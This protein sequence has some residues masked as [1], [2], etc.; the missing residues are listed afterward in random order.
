MHF[1]K[2]SKEIPAVGINAE[3]IF[4]ASWWPLILLFLQKKPCVL[5]PQSSFSI[6]KYTFR[7]YP[8]FNCCSV[9]VLP[10]WWK[11]GILTCTLNDTLLTHYKLY[12]LL[13]KHYI[14]CVQQ[15]WTMHHGSCWR[16]CGKR[17]SLD[18]QG[19]H[20][21]RKPKWFL[22]TMRHVLDTKGRHLPGGIW[23]ISKRYYV[24]ELHD[25]HTRGRMQ[26]WQLKMVKVGNKALELGRRKEQSQSEG[27]INS[28]SVW[29]V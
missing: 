5:M 23:K 1:D 12:N 17:K 7:W 9:N 2:Y 13:L 8:H 28:P 10:R 29:W 3:T 27:R 18:C 4:K 21:W 16:W 19:R 20:T 15:N 25:H 24:W 6:L 26:L 22:N 14:T 11:L